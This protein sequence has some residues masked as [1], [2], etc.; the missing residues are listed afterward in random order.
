MLLLVP[1][2]EERCVACPE[3]L[4]GLAILLGHFPA[5]DGDPLFAIRGS[6]LRHTNL[7][8]WTVISPSNRH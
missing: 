8:R 5:C 1:A 7:C 4:D 3:H 6:L 2:E